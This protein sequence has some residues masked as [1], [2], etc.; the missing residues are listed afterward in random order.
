LPRSYGYMHL[1]TCVPKPS[2]MKCDHILKS[3]QG[4]TYSRLLEIRRRS[5]RDGN[6]APL[7]ISEK[8]LFHCALWVAKARGK[9]SN[10]RLVEQV[11]EIA[12]KLLGRFGKIGNSI[13]RAGRKR[14]GMIRD[15]YEKPNGVFGWAPQVRQWLSDERYVW[16][17]GVLGMGLP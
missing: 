14:A 4:L 15:I 13:L 16:Y 2:R 3:D 9:I 7:R 17:L 5:L 10:S 1:S 12:L 11:K 6:W 8:A